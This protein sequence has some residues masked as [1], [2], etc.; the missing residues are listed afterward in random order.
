KIFFV[1]LILFFTIIS[2]FSDIAFD[3]LDT[4]FN[5]PEMIIGNI[6]GFFTL[7]LIVYAIS[8]PFSLKFCKD[9]RY[10]LRRDFIEIKKGIIKKKT[11][12]VPYERVQNIRVKRE[13]FQRPFGIVNLEIETAGDWRRRKRNRFLGNSEGV[14]L[15]V[16][17]PE[18]IK[19]LIYSRINNLL[20]R[21]GDVDGLGS[22]QRSFSGCI[23]QVRYREALES[24]LGVVIRD[25]QELNQRI[26]RLISTLDKFR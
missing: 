17:H 3:L 20:G 18:F 8:I 10:Y 11:V 9:Y 19:N 6:I 5:L 7:F 1:E 4:L 16:K 24:G 15:G 2:Q 13:I 14:I 26:D 23:N 21:Y 12:Q 25:F 22:I